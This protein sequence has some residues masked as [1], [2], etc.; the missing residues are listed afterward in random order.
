MLALEMGLGKSAVTVN[1]IANHQKQIRAA[2]I[3]CPLSVVSVWAGSKAIPGQFD[4]HAT[5]EA[6]SNMIIV[7]LDKGSLEKR[8]KHA[9][10]MHVMAMKQGK[11]F[12]CII[13]Y[14]SVWR[15]TFAHWAVTVPWD[16]VV[17]DELHRIKSPGAKASKFFGRLE[18]IAKRRLGLSGT[19][20]PHSPMDIYSQ[21]RFLDPGVFGRSFQRFRSDYAVMGGFGGHQVMSFK[22][23]EDLHNRMYFIAYRAKSEDVFDLPEFVDLYR[24]FDLNLQERVLYEQMDQEFA[25][26]VDNNVITADNALVKLLR[27]QQL[28]GGHIDGNVIGDSKKQLLK[29]ILEDLPA[30]EPVVVFAKFTQDL[31]HIKD[32]CKEL[33]RPFSEVSGHKKELSD[34]QAGNSTIL[35][36]QIQSGKEGVDFTRAR[37]C[38]YYSLGFSLGDYMQS[39]KRIHRPGQKR[40]CFYIHLV[41]N[42][43]VDEKVIKALHDKEEIVESV[44]QQYKE[45]KFFERKP[46][47]GKKRNY[48]FTEG[49]LK[50]LYGE[51][52]GGL[53]DIAKGFPARYR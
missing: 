53:A 2:L 15:H 37:Y 23:I 46:K 10:T 5:P 39:R 4:Q 43:S 36:V 52:H 1:I 47:E 21:Y 26:A 40:G 22:N 18:G 50:C 27:L 12:I 45:R 49:D 29:D 7:A 9:Q 35:G 16:L 17:G 34:W 51:L 6:R 42:D 32:V 8:T 48:A 14:E 3:V 31:A 19:P 30:D 25:V 33:D 13:N 20:L 41:A 38:I 11:Q 28:T 24:N 44:L